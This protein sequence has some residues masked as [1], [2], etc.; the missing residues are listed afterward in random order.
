MSIDPT[1]ITPQLTELQRILRETLEEDG[2]LSTALIQEACSD[3]LVDYTA[4]CTGSLSE[5]FLATS[6]GRRMT[7]LFNPKARL[8]AE[9]RRW[10]YVYAR[11]VTKWNHN[12]SLCDDELAGTEDRY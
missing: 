8:N 9:Y 10:C 12:L 7:R 2:S 3:V 6:N 4:W 1:I 11:E 5:Q